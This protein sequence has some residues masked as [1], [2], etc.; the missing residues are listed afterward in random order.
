M[1]RILGVWRGG[2]W[3]GWQNTAIR[4]RGSKKISTTIHRV[5]GEQAPPLGPS[6]PLSGRGVR[7]SVRPCVH[8]CRRGKVVC[9]V[10]YACCLLRGLCLLCPLDRLS[11]AAGV[12]AEGSVPRAWGSPHPASPLLGH[13]PVRRLLRSRPTRGRTRTRFPLLPHSPLATP[14]PSS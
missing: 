14:L 11:G 8:V 6:L 3:Y 13:W 9:S 4:K 12:P 5:N 7:A 10:S 1:K 2:E